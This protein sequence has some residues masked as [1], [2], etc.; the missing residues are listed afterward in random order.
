MAGWEGRRLVV[1]AGREDEGD[2]AGRKRQSHTPT[3]SFAGH[4][5]GLEP[6]QQ[7]RV[8]LVVAQ[9]TLVQHVARHYD[10]VRLQQQRRPPHGAPEAPVAPA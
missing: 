6:V 1:V 8:L 4:E 9:L 3:I 5:D 7:L 10:G 2:G